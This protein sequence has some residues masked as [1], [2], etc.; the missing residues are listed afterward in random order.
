MAETKVTGVLAAPM[1]QI[2]WYNGIV[3]VGISRK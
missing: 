2:K 1:A 3:A